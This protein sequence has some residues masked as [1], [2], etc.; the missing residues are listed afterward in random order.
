MNTL[1][2][3]LKFYGLGFGI[4]LVFVFFFFRNR[5]CT[6]L[7]D[8]RV[9]NTILERVIVLNDETKAYLEANKI[10][11]SL[12]ITFLNDGDIAFGQSK[13]QGNP[14]VYEVSKE[15]GGKTIKLWFTLPKDAFISEVIIPKN[16]IHSVKNSSNGIA[17]MTHFP[18]VSNLVF[19]ADDPLFEKQWKSLGIK[20]AKHVFKRL[21]ASG[22][23]DF[24]KSNLNKSPQPEQKIGF[25]LV[26]GDTVTA[27][28]T[29]YKDHIQFFD[30]DE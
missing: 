6:W 11:D 10:S 28:T 19:L 2:R 25:T 30:F 16:S 21:K 20:D 18:N 7:P 3:R 5:G 8:N 24:S 29:W 26:Q 23:I 13:K 14:Q 17:H 1:L 9:K 4:G 22:Y 27:T 15:I 12:M